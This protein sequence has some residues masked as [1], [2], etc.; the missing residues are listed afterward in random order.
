MSYATYE[1][2]IQTYKGQL[3]STEQFNQ[4][5]LEASAY[6]D[7]VTFDQA[8]TVVDTGTDTTTIEKIQKATCA[9][10]EELYRQNLSLNGVISSESVGQHSVSYKQM[11]QKDGEAKK[12]RL[13]K[14]FLA[15]SGLMYGSEAITT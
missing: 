2:Y 6:V 9:I 1:F 15:S 14:L 8:A 11:S 3:L 13:A 12:F 4:F 10:A 7:I 5:S